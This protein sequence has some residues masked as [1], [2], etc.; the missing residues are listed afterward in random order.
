MRTSIVLLKIINHVISCDLRYTYNTEYYYV[1]IP[2]KSTNNYHN[3]TT[4]YGIYQKDLYAYRQ[5]KRTWVILQSGDKP[6]NV[7]EKYYVTD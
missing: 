7:D 4:L 2:F 1:G 6:F 3:T 5:C